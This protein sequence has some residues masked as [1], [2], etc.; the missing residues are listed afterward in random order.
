MAVFLTDFKMAAAAVLNLLP[1][2][3][4]SIWSSLDSGWGCSCKIS[5]LYMNIW[6]IKLCPKKQNGGRRHLELLFRNRG[7][8]TKSTSRP[9]HCVK[10]SRQSHYYFRRCGHFNIL[11][12]WLK[13]PIPAPKIYVFFGGVLP[14]NIT[15][16]H[17]DPQKALPW[18]NRVIWAIKRRDRSSGLIGTAWQEYKQ[19]SIAIA[20]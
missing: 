10:I 9:E 6:V 7:P 17:R 14:L 1:V 3:I 15:F 19:D 11:Q 4:F 18:R 12:I 16:R 5:C 13:T 20:Q 8:P 2:S